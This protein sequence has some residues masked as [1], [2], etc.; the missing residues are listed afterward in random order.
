MAE[1]Q[2]EVDAMLDDLLEGKSPEE[3]MGAGGLLE[4]LTKRLLERGLEGELTDH[5]GMESTKPRAETV[6]TR[7]MAGPGSD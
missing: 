7:A 2:K 6:A 4:D 3:V 5:L 1:K